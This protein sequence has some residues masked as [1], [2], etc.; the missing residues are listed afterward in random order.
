MKN[1][2]KLLLS[3][4]CVIMS[5]LA[6]AGTTFALNAES[7]E[8]EAGEIQAGSV[9]CE[10]FYADSFEKVI[11][12]QSKVSAENKVI[13]GG[14]KWEPGYSQLQYFSTENTG[15]ADFNYNFIFTKATDASEGVLDEVIDV[16][17]KKL[18][19]SAIASYSDRN[20]F[21]REAVYAGSLKSVIANQKLLSADAAL[22]A[23]S[24]DIYVIAL[25]LNDN[26]PDSY[27]GTFCTEFH[28][29]L[30]ATNQTSNS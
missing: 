13:F 23:N 25:K 11:D 28:I 19:S 8:T 4:L 22:A 16:Y 10:L 7:A 2:N 21:F 26:A 14:D 12:S 29:Q 1:K 27:E 18:D 9:A 20:S 30:V 15:T 24:N 6:V 3:M 17:Y 5:C